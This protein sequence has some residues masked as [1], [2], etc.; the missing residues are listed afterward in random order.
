ANVTSAGV[1]ATGDGW[2][3]LR[4]PMNQA[5]AAALAAKLKGTAAVDPFAFKNLDYVLGANAAG[6]SFLVGFGAKSP[7]KP[8]H[9]NVYL[10]DANPGDKST[11]AIPDRNAQAGILMGGTLNPGEYKDDVESYQHTEGCIDYNAGLVATLGY[12]LASMAPVDTMKFTGKGTNGIR[13]KGQRLGSRGKEA[14]F[15]VDGLGRLME[16]LPAAK[17]VTP[18]LRLGL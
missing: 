12:V 11:L 16:A 13:M 15:Y 5:F 2:G 4:F 9:R 10:N 17:R 8:H 7:R 14:A 6:Q 18:S 1:G 3:R